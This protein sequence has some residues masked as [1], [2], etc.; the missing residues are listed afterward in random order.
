MSDELLHQSKPMIGS[1]QCTK[2]IGT[3]SNNMV[4]MAVHQTTGKL[5]A[6]RAMTVNVTN[7]EEAIE[8]CKA[9]LA[10][11]SVLDTPNIVPIEDYGSDGSTVYMALRFMKGGSLQE[12][13]K[14]RQKKLGS[15]AEVP[16]PSVGEILAMLDRVALALDDLHLRDV[17]H[18]QIEPRN[19]M[20]DDVGQA[21]VA[22][23]GLTRLLKIIFSLDATTSFNTNRYTAP[24]LWSGERPLPATDQYSL[25]CI[26]YELFTGKP[27][28]DAPTIFGLMKQHS[29][30]IPLPPHYVR[31]HL[32]ADL[33]LPFWQA[34]AKPPERRY[35]SVRAFVDDL[36]QVFVGRE[37]T[38]TG[39]FTFE[40]G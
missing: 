2:L 7:R 40:L 14:Q 26:A 25:A 39:F 18:G 4:Y 38:P 9:E 37:G 3:P 21:Y 34:L 32:P 8:Q 35:R 12:R 31:D 5:V 36:R 30:E 1:Y 22:D 13:L 15:G 33:A 20:F 29:D 6:L 17:V 10:S 28:F 19:L 27:A 24:E 16:L 23:I 11:F